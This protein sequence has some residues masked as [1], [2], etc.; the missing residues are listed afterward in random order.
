MKKIKFC[1]Y[2]FC[3]M[4][5]CGWS[6]KVAHDIYGTVGLLQLAGV[7]LPVRTKKIEVEKVVE[8]ERPRMKFDSALEERLKTASVPR[9]IVEGVLMQEDESRSNRMSLTRYE[10]SY[11]D[12][13]RRYTNNPDEQRLWASSWCPFQ[14]MAP[15]VKEFKL[16]DWSDLLDPETCVHVG[17]SIL[18]RCW[19]E[20]KGKNK[21][22]KVYN[23][24][25][26]YNGPLG[27]RYADRLVQHVSRA[28]VN[29]VLRAEG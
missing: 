7:Q 6:G 1:F 27:Q 15:W 2:S 28:A 3:A 22:E 5:I 20:A 18:E 17:M 10:Q 23:T 14:V 12:K 26:C 19:K 21:L 29:E 13:A 24:G 11:L 25:I 4:A 8:V 16:D 9:I